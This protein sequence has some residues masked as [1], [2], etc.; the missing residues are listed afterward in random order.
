MYMC[1]NIWWFLSRIFGKVIKNIIFAL[2]H[3]FTSVYFSSSLLKK[4]SVK[5]KSDIL[6]NAYKFLVSFF[7]KHM[8]NALL[9]LISI[10]DNY[11]QAYEIIIF[12]HFRIQRKLKISK[13][14]V[15]AVFL[16]H[17]GHLHSHSMALI[18]DMWCGWFSLS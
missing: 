18:G 14:R 12:K 10:W 5:T 11:F 15:T 8:I 2:E 7:I 6:Q 17:L 16:H 13:Y 3:I 9:V 4:I 1:R